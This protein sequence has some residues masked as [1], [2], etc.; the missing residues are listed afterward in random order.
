MSYQMGETG[1]QQ[2]NSE[3]R[4]GNAPLLRNALEYPYSCFLA[5]PPPPTKEGPDSTTAPTLTGSRVDRPLPTPTRFPSLR[6]PISAPPPPV[7]GERTEVYLRHRDEHRSRVYQ[8]VPWTTT[9]AAW[10]WLLDR[11]D[12]SIGRYYN[13]EV[14]VI[15]VQYQ[16]PTIKPILHS[17]L[18]AHVPPPWE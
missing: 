10:Y 6:Q 13:H 4:I 5:P 3:L 18:L 12:L 7:P 17:F 16:D 14:Q 11:C 1:G 9:S 8:V 15:S 2:P